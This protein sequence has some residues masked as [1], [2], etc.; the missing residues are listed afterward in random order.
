MNI[1]LEKKKTARFL[2]IIGV[3]VLIAIYF[4]MHARI[5]PEPEP[6]DVGFEH[7]HFG[8][9]GSNSF[10]ISHVFASSGSEYPHLQP[11]FDGPRSGPFSIGLFFGALGIIGIC[12]FFIIRSHKNNSS[13]IKWF[14]LFISLCLLLIFSIFYAT[15]AFDFIE[16]MLRV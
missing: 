4:L 9:C 2:I 13:R 7:Y 5:W 12:I 15:G 16:Y 1:F 6:C 3:T 8:H 10:V 11:Q 14:C